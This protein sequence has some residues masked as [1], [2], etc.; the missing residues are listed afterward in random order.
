MD[1]NLPGLHVHGLFV[2]A[3]DRWLPAFPGDLS[4]TQIESGLLHCRHATA[5]ASRPSSIN[6]VSVSSFRSVNICLH[7]MLWCWMHKYFQ[8]FLEGL[9]PLLL[10][11]GPI[12]L[13]SLVFDLKVCFK[14]WLPLFS[15]DFHLHGNKCSFSILR[16]SFSYVPISLSWSSCCF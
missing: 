10:Y 1:G 9:P 15:F 11:N 13:P 8:L 7:T 2:K 12:Q 14:F 4:Q 5:W 6:K 16:F 3:L